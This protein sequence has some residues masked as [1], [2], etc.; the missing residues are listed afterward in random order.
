MGRHP[1]ECL[2]P[3]QKS[4]LQLC[5]CLKR[6]CN[7]AGVA[8]VIELLSE[9]LYILAMV[10]QKIRLRVLT[11]ATA[12]VGKVLATLA[13][14]WVGIFSEA[15]ALSLAQ[16]LVCLT[17]LCRKKIRLMRQNTLR[18]YLLAGKLSCSLGMSVDTVK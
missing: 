17:P 1:N 5:K 15:I 9:P 3:G 12:T 10:Q 4:F 7:R 6:A 8:A 14:L 2:S 11:E 13:L 16:V 18:S